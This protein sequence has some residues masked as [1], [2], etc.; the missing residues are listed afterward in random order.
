M[1]KLFGGDPEAKVRDMLSFA[2]RPGEEV[3]DPWW[4]RDFQSTWED[5][6]AGCRGLLKELFGVS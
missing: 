1:L 3:A 4:S 2:G 6:E 5:L